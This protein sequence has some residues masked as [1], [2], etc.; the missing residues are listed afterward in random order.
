MQR[1]AP[2]PP[3][4]TPF[5]NSDGFVTEP[6]RQFLMTVKMN[7][8]TGQIT[9]EDVLAIPSGNPSQGEGVAN[10]ALRAAMLDRPA[11]DFGAAVEDIQKLVLAQGE[12]RRLSDELQALILQVN[13]ARSEIIDRDARV[14]LAALQRPIA[15]IPLLK[16]DADYTGETG[17]IGS[18]TL[19]TVPKAGIYEIS[20]YVVCSM[21]GAG[22]VDTTLAWTDGSGAKSATLLST[23]SLT[24]L[25]NFDSGRITIYADAET[26][27][28]FST[29]TAGIV[30]AAYDLHIRLRSLPLF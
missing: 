30:A 3:F 19:Y 4:R 21:A 1:Q 2:G 17:D 27:I 22:T 9:Q 6:W 14:L 18:T 23:V 25:A 12:A 5:V 26:T 28:D 29:T 7:A 16:A 13:G 15:P 24:N 20:A 11:R 10:S 8:P